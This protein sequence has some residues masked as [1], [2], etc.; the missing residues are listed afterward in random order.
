MKNGCNLETCLM[1]RLCVKEWIPAI[2]ANKKNF[3]LN[4]GESL[5]S[6]GD[7]VNGIYFIYQGTVKVHKHWS[8]DKELILRFAADGE[9]VGHRGLGRDNLFPVSATA[10]HSTTVCFVD[11]EFFQSSLHV[12]HDFLYNLMLFYASELKDSEGNMRNLAHMTV[13][14]RTAVALMALERKFGTDAAGDI[15]IILSRQDLSSFVGTSYE[16]LF[17]MLNE[18]IAAGIIAQQDKKFRIINRDMLKMLA[19]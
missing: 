17:R 10:I 15:N 6:E 3:Q 7:F 11:M 16:T 19:R 14:G 4:R 8:E 12:N 13:K 18:L 2:S 9:I 1:C 5:F